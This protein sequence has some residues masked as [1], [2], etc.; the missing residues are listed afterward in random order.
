MIIEQLDL[1]SILMVMCTNSYSLYE[2][3]IKLGTTK[4]KHLM[5]NIMALRQLYERKE[6]VEIK[7]IDRKDNPTN[8]MTKSTPNK[9][10]K[11]FMDSN[12]L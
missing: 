5:I 7:W 1:L 11:R 2:C 12:Q 8:A 4:E 9:A 3:L 6:I 10:L